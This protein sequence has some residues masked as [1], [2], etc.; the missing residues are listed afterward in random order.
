MPGTPV[1]AQ[2]ATPGLSAGAREVRVPG[3][4]GAGLKS[5]GGIQLTKHASTFNNGK[6]AAAR[7]HLFPSCPRIV[8]AAMRASSILLLIPRQSPFLKLFCPSEHSWLTAVFGCQALCLL[9]VGIRDAGNFEPGI[10]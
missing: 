7:L 1:S 8:R 10:L 6:V 9:A 4:E 3:M 5:E 2:Q